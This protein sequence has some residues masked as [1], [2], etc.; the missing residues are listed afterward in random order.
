EA[1]DPRSA[2][3]AADIVL[4]MGSSALRALS[5]GRPLIVQ[6]EEG[7]SRV[8]EPDSAGLFLH[9]GFYGLDSGREGPEVLAVQ[10]ERLLVDKPLRDE[11]GQMGRS[12]VEENFSLDALSNRLLD[13]YKTVSRQKA[14]FIPGEVASVLGKAFQRELQNHQPKRKQQKKLLESLKLRSAA[15]GAWPPANL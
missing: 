1:G 10:I 6:G 15:S 9:Q 14:P 7:F 13:I 4:G 11:L 8:F 5:I 12:I 2:Y 3:A